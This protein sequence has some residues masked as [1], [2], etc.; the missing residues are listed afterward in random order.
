MLSVIAS[1]CA[2]L[3][4]AVLPLHAESVAWITGRVDTIPALFFLGSFLAYALWRRGEEKSTRLY[5]CSLA[6]FFCALFSKQ[7]TII[8]VATL[9]LYDLV[10]ERRPIRVSWSWLAPYV[11]FAALTI[12]YLL[13][14]YVLF[15]EVAR[16]GQL[17]ADGLGVSRIFV[18][19]HFQRMFFGGEV[20]RYPFGYIAALLVTAL[21]WLLLRASGAATLRHGS[22]KVL[23]FGPCWWVLNLAPL[24]VVGYESTRHVY[25]ASVG[26]AVIVGLVFH[27]MWHQR[28]AAFRYATLVA[29][30]GLVAF[31][32]VGLHAE[33]EEWNVRARVSQKVVADLEREALATPEGS[34]LIVGAPVRSWEWA[35]PFAAE[36]PFTRVELAERVS[37]VSP[38]LIDCCREQWMERTRRHRAGLVAT[39][40]R[41]AGGA[42][43]GR[44][45]RSV[46]EVDRSRVPCA[47]ESGD[48]AARSR[49]VRGPGSSDVDDPPTGPLTGLR[50]ATRADRP[51]RCDGGCPPTNNLRWLPQPIRGAAE[52]R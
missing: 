35:L 17:T 38:V 19:K 51:P 21:A 47:P 50:E 23:Y 36:R 26:W 22:S 44:W 31:Y 25:L 14:R 46:L 52:T 30:A 48:N 10:A 45:N 9:F 42:Q 7:N 1:T 2:A 29:S 24:V 37:I 39:G 16:E 18:G 12:A 40:I 8:M 6:L 34:L 20:S 27:A 15:G 13:L 11:P 49:Y 4:F 43:L 33:V 41:A 5:L 3:V 28:H 32:T